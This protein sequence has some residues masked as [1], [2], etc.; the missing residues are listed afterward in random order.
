[1]EKI[2]KKDIHISFHPIN[3]FTLSYI[4]DN[5]R[6]FKHHYIGYGIQEAKTLFKILIQQG[7]KNV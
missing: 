4:S 6:Y 2:R 5:N 1:M 7:A 3:G